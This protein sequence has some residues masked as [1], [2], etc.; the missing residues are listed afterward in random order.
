MIVIKICPCAIR[1][2]VFKC[3]VHSG[4]DFFRRM[5]IEVYKSSN[6]AHGCKYKKDFGWWMMDSG[7]RNRESGVR[8]VVVVGN[9]MPGWG[10]L[11]DFKKSAF[12]WET[13]GSHMGVVWER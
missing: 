8:M 1:T 10:K 4:K 6:A 12:M 7:I 9:R 11:T 5:F 13:Y 3:V 2:P